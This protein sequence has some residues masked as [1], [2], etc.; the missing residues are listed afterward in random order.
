MKKILVMLGPNLNMVGTREKNIYGE[1]NADTINQ[2]IKSF[3][4]NIG[5][6]CDIFQSN[7]EGDL[8]DK[9][10]S[11][12]GVYDGV[13]LNAGALTHYSYALRDAIASVT[14]VPFIEVHMSNV[15]K[16]EEFRHKSVISAVCAGVICGFGKDSY[17]LGIEALKGLI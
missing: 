4:E 16:R 5:F 12:L 7:H 14:A 9:I 17:R 1:E 6:E 8:I 2:D 3:A 13:V 15:H 10:H 11:T